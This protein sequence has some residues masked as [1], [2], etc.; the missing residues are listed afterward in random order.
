MHSKLRIPTGFRD[1][2]LD[3]CGVQYNT[4]ARRVLPM[5]RIA[6]RGRTPVAVTG[7]PSQCVLGGLAC[8]AVAVMGAETQ[9]I[10]AAAA[11][12]PVAIVGV[13][14]TEIITPGGAGPAGTM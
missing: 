2:A 9:R 7:S 10:A 4:P 12:A 13:I 14:P 6:C 5:R 11:V 3:N 8:G 1:E